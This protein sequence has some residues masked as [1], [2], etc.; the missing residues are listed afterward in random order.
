[1]RR[2]SLQ[3]LLVTTAYW[4]V[5][6]CSLLASS[7]D[8]QAFE[9]N[10][11]QT[12]E[13]QVADGLAPGA[14]LVAVADG[15]L[16]IHE[17]YGVD[18]ELFNLGS[19]TSSLS[20]LATLHLLHTQQ[21]GLDEPISDLDVATDFL[22]QLDDSTD[23]WNALSWRYLLD[24]RSGLTE[25]TTAIRTPSPDTHRALDESLLSHFP[26]FVATPGQR[27][28]PSHHASALAGLLAAQASGRDYPTFLE[29]FLFSPLG[30][31]DAHSLAAGLPDRELAQGHIR[32]SGRLQP[33]PHRGVGLSPVDGLYVSGDDMAALLNFLT[34]PG[35]EVAEGDLTP[36]HR[37][38]RDLRSTSFQPHPKV[39]GV[40][41][42]LTVRHLHGE[43]W[44]SATGQS[45]DGFSTL[46]LFSPQRRIGIYVGYNSDLG[47]SLREELVALF[48][49]P[50]SSELELA[51]GDRAE[52][53]I[54]D[55]RGTYRHNRT[56][57]KGFMKPIGALMALR[58]SLDHHRSDDDAFDEPHLELSLS[59]DRQPLVWRPVAD[60]DDLWQSHDGRHHLVVER[61]EDHGITGFYHDAPEL[62][63][64]ERLPAHQHGSLVAAL[65]AAFFMIFAAAF[66]GWPLLALARRFGNS[67]SDVEDIDDGVSDDSKSAI[68]WAVAY[69]G[70]ALTFWAGYAILAGRQVFGVPDWA[71]LLF[72]LPLVLILLS[73]W[74]LWHSVQNFQKQRGSAHFRL[75]YALVTAAAWLMI[76]ALYAWDLLGFQW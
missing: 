27:F 3:L 16:V 17:T 54:D 66:V 15:Q 13:E 45:A 51:T 57:T 58:A 12:V 26:T 10:L 19:A 70:V 68:A 5:V 55:I 8:A 14:Q 1:M 65:I 69:A 43:P 29:D 53:R 20:A 48:D 49:Q 61:D 74:L 71:Y 46:I 40:T 22:H 23:A 25:S 9:E 73:P 30:M 62:R 18:D 11:Q 21:I 36:L 59:M 37:A 4:M 63:G 42:G 31:D 33:Q 41:P 50:T 75:A 52:A 72:S 67:Q 47:A 2:L 44:L 24:H 38:L 76:P 35:D 56:V 34:L 7:A 32:V 64:F 28:Q 60:D 39:S 6:S